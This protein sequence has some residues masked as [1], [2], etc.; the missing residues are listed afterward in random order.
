VSTLRQAGFAMLEA[1][2]VQR[3]NIKNILIKNVID[4]CIGAMVYWLFGFSFS[5]GSRSSNNGVSSN[6]GFIGDDNWALRD[7]EN[8]ENPS[9][10]SLID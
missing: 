1:G 6:N 7:Y 10:C 2:V 8:D 3:K 5:Y 9:E 4:I